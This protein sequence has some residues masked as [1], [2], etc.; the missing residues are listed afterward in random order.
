[1]LP[2]TIQRHRPSRSPAEHAGISLLHSG[3]L[4]AAATAA[5]ALAAVGTLAFG[6][7]ANRTWLILALVLAVPFA[8]QREFGR[9]YAFARLDVANALILDAAVAALQLSALGWL[10]W[11]GRLSAV[12]ACA[13]LGGACALTSFVWLYCMRSNFVIRVEQLWRATGESWALGKWLCAGQVAVSIQGYASYWVLP[14]LVSMNETGVYAACTSIASLANPLLTAYRNTLTPR[15]VLAFKEGGGAMLRR[16]AARDALRARGRD[17]PLLRRDLPRRRHAYARRLSRP[18][19][20]R[21]KPC[22]HCLSDRNDGR[23]GGGAGFERAGEHGA[24]T[25]DR[26]GDLGRDRDHFGC[27][28]ES[29]RSNGDCQGR[30]MGSWQETS[31][32]P[33]PV[34]RRSWPLS[35]GPRQRPAV[36][37]RWCKCY[38]SSR[39]APRTAAGTSDRS[40]KGLKARF[41]AVSS[42]GGRALWRKGTA[43]WWSSCTNRMGRRAPRWRS[44]SSTRRRGCTSA[45]DGKTGEGW[46]IRAPLPLHLSASPP[47]L[48]MTMAAGAQLKS[49]LLDKGYASRELLHSAARAIV[50]VMRPY[51][52]A[53]RLHGDLS[54][55]NILWDP[56][57]RA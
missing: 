49:S 6:T 1:M 51:W 24:S 33:P 37:H 19:I 18:G 41:I 35:R 55:H 21:T 25:D 34:G 13:A 15:A 53:G 40:R 50:A 57:D 14:L 7:N 26:H 23:G 3:L 54:F 22:R 43:I 9:T 8:M 56:S 47:A 46:T 29:F 27:S 42:H 32:A 45:V 4:A 39:R 10:G 52:A 36:L 2:Y 20:R 48:V 30:P 5:L 38:D 16:Q 31:P 11:T 12:G 44:G 17:V 28:L